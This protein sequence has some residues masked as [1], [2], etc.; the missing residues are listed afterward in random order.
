MTN[1]AILG[2]GVVGSGIAEVIAKNE[3]PVRRMTA[4]VINVK[5]ILDKRDFPNSP[6]GSAASRQ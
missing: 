5:Y 2:F 6:P 4:D 3:L 1:I